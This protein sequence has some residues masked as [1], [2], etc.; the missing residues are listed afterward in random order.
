[1]ILLHYTKHFFFLNFEIF[2]KF[3]GIN[4]TEFKTINIMI[5]IYRGEEERNY[6]IRFE[7]MYDL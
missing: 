3:R 4:G 5:K 7:T 1:M 6:V 2:T